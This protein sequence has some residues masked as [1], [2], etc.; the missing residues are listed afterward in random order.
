[1][2]TI[3]GDALLTCLVTPYYTRKL[4]SFLPQGSLYRIPT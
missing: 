3:I 4:C 2:E 1:M